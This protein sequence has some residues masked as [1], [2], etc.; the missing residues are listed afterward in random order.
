M[1]VITTLTLLM[2]L[3]IASPYIYEYLRIDAI[4]SGQRSD[5]MAIRIMYWVAVINNIDVIGLMGHGILAARSFLPEYSAYYN[6]EPNV[7][8][9]YLNTFLDLGFVGISLYLGFFISLYL[10]MRTMNKQI[11]FV[12][13]SCAFIM[14]CTLYTAYDIEMWTFLC[15]SLVITRLY[16][17]SL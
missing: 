17:S 9:L 14:S 12:T 1:K 7:H 16:K 3:A 2:L 5:G 4:I 6:G 8:N 13:I 15:C 11:A 10:L